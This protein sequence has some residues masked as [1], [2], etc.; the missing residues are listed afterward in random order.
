MVN[1]RLRPNVWRGI[2][3]SIALWTSGHGDGGVPSAHNGSARSLLESGPKL[4]YRRCL[5]SRRGGSERVKRWIGES[6]NRISR[7]AKIWA[8]INNP[9]GSLTGITDYPVGDAGNMAVYLADDRDISTIL[10]AQALGNTNYWTMSS[11]SLPR[12]RR[13]FYELDIKMLIVD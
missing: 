3:R 11:E 2:S 6:G 12:S 4:G 13:H 9:G 10:S 1:P 7:K 8:T 5:K